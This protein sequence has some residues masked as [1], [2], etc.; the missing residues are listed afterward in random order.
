MQVF[1]PVARGDR[2]EL[3]REVCRALGVKAGEW[4]RI[5]VTP[6]EYAVVEKVPVEVPDDVRLHREETVT[7]RTG[8]E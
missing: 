5:R 6:G 4:L 8:G 1:A 7:D 3:P 2:V